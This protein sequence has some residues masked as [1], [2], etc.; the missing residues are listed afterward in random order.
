M[1]TLQKDH[2]MQSKQFQIKQGVKST[3]RTEEVENEK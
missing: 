1:Q 2:L 3:P